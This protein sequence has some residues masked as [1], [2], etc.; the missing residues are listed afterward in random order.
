VGFKIFSN[1]QM[2]MAELGP[3]ESRIVYGEMDWRQINRVAAA[4][5]KWSSAGINPKEM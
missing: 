2:Q 5:A 4:V 3:L 1:Q